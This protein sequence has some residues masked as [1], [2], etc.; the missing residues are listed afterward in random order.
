LIETQ[1]PNVDWPSVWKIIRTKVL[2]SD[3]ISL[4]FKMVHRLLTTRDIIERLGL[5]EGQAGLCLHCRLEV[6]DLIQCIF[7]CPRNMLVGLALLGC[8]QHLIP[9]LSA[10]A[11]VRL[12]YGLVLTYVDILAALCILSTGLKYIWEA[13][14]AKKVVMKYNMMAIL[15]T[16]RHNSAHI[17]Y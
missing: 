1:N 14:F 17:S 12:D 6:E 5:Y 2:G 16:S 15:R 8:V 4:Q 11:A 10:E 13:R 7:D 3:L 9:G